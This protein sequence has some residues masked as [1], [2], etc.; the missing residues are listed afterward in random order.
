MSLCARVCASGV[1]LGS[2]VRGGI[3]IR[4]NAFHA[5]T[6]AQTLAQKQDPSVGIDVSDLFSAVADVAK[7]QT[8]RT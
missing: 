3:S 1:F 5:N 2:Q 4:F 8:Q 6:L 7:W